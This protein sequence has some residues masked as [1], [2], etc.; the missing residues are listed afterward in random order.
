MNCGFV[1][2]VDPE[3]P[4]A[5]EKTLA[6]LWEMYENVNNAKIQQDIKHAEVVY[7]LTEENKQLEKTCSEV[8]DVNRCIID[9]AKSMLAN[10]YQYKDGRTTVYNK[11]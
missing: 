5:L 3:W 4:S 10:K 6:K 11:G 2:W 8:A 1:E 9:S 7:A